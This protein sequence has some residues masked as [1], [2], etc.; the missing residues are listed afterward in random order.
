MASKKPA[1]VSSKLLGLKFMQR[2]QAKEDLACARKMKEEQV[3][4]QLEVRSYLY[5]LTLLWSLIPLCTRCASRCV[6]LVGCCFT[7]AVFSG[8]AT[9]P[10]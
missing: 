3:K 1:G 10:S 6:R 8:L 9:R 5:L 2:A 7:I 4:A